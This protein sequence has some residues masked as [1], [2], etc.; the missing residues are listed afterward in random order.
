MRIAP[1]PQSGPSS[2]CTQK[3][4]RGPRPVGHIARASWKKLGPTFWSASPTQR[5]TIACK[6]ARATTDRTYPKPQTTE[7]GTNPAGTGGV[8]HCGPRAVGYSNPSGPGRVISLAASEFSDQHVGKHPSDVDGTGGDGGW[9]GQETLGLQTQDPPSMLGARQ[10]AQVS[11]I[12]I[13]C[14]TGQK[15]DHGG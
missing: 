14:R 12:L 1:S 7:C 13:L 6:N 2:P 5:I 11:V 8:H 3:Q 10:F 9:Q 15:W 4:K